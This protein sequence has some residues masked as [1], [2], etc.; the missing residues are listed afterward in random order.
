MN[1]TK[2][3]RIIRA[4]IVPREIIP[5]LRRSLTSGRSMPAYQTA[6]RAE[7]PAMAP[8][9]DGW[10]MLS[11][12]TSDPTYPN[13]LFVK[14]KN[15]LRKLTRGIAAF[16]ILKSELE[17]LSSN[18]SR[19][20]I[21]EIPNDDLLSDDVIG[22]LREVNRALFAGQVDMYSI[23]ENPPMKKGKLVL[24]YPN[25]NSPRQIR[26][27]NEFNICT[28]RNEAIKTAMM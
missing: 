6:P 12:P 23:A 16:D 18:R 1:P 27:L 4:G 7:L 25:T 13:L 20:L 8:P 17:F 19:K 15:E 14:F 24:F 5:Y 28:Y 22:L 10:L 11:A 9:P 2:L 26:S 21:L 3:N